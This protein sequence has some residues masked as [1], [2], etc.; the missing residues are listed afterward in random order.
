M[1]PNLGKKNAEVTCENAEKEKITNINIGPS[2]GLTLHYSSTHQPIQHTIL[3]LY[4][5]TLYLSSFRFQICSNMSFETETI[6][7][8]SYPSSL[9]A[10][11]EESDLYLDYPPFS[12]PILRDDQEAQRPTYPWIP[13]GLPTSAQPEQDEDDCKYPP[14]VLEQMS[15]TGLS[16]EPEVYF[17]KVRLLRFHLGQ[18]QEEREKLRERV[19][20]QKKEQKEKEEMIKIKDEMVK[21]LEDQLKA[22][23][24]EIKELQ[25]EA[26]MLL[27]NWV[28]VNLNPEGLMLE[29]FERKSS[30]RKQERKLKGPEN[31]LKARKRTK[32]VHESG[33]TKRYN[34]RSGKN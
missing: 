15:D 2:L 27:E 7:D 4:Q 32:E 12:P 9:Y 16:R 26:D 34:T 21:M 11:E 14:H 33:V 10:S 13:H 31:K 29:V 22:Q 30:M 5:L 25:R 8:Q 3:Q 28:W 20:E 23:E 18:M 1:Q 19:E 24:E 17:H 6:Y